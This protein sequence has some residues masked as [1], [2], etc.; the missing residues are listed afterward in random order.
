MDEFSRE[1]FFFQGTVEAE[2][3]SRVIDSNE[4]F[5]RKFKDFAPERKEEAGDFR[6]SE[7]DVNEAHHLKAF[8]RL[9]AEDGVGAHFGAGHGSNF[10][11]GIE[12]EELFN[13]LCS[14]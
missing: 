14:L 12:F 5:G 1:L 13:E 11:V 10:Q 3:E 7:S 2:I 8:H 6:Q 9:D 4:G